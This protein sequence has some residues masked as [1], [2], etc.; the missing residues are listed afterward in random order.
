VSGAVSLEGNYYGI[1]VSV[2]RSGHETAGVAKV[3]KVV[4]ACAAALTKRPRLV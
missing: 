3:V 4:K 1:V 2:I